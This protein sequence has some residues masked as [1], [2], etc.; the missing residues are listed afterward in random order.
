[1]RIVLEAEDS[2]RLL[3]GGGELVLE[4]GPAVGLSPFHL[5]AAA[6]ATCTWS[7]LEGWAR[8]A[9]LGADALAILVEWDLGG[10]PVRVSNVRMEVA[11]PELPAG[12]EAA[13]RRVASHCTIHHTLELGTHVSTEIRRSE[14]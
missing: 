7:V 2:I 1:M 5:L 12:R 13:A 9:G 3:P 6:L 10:D 14:S 11:W 8:E 4:G